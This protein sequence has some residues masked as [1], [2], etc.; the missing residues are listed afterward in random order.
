MA[1][2]P[3]VESTAAEQNDDDDD[4]EKGIEVHCF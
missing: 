3:Q 2:A 4:E 1:L